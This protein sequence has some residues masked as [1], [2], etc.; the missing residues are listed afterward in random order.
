MAGVPFPGG[1]RVGQVMVRGV[2]GATTVDKNVASE[3]LAATRELLQV[4]QQ[5]NDLDPGDIISVFFTATPDLNAVF[6]AAAA[7]D[8]GWD[9]VPLLDA[10]EMDAPGALPHRVR[11]LMH[12]Y[13]DRDSQAVEHIYL[14]GAAV[15]RPDLRRRRSSSREGDGMPLGSDRG[16]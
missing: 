11:V 15:L 9:A 2:R 1:A 12:A 6:P 4:M 13:T 10:V 5:A 8:L 3:I 14:R 16:R 7:R